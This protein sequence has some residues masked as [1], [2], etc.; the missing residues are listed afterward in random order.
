MTSEATTQNELRR[1]M[2]LTSPHKSLMTQ[3][4]YNT[5][6]VKLVMTGLVALSALA[7][8]TQDTGILGAVA[9]GVIRDH[10]SK[11]T[12]SG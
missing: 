12:I 4:Y 2:N 7:V 3:Y 1:N 5:G 8:V 9:G 10:D 6:L 11:D